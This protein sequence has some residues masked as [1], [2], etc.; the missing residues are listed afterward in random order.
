MKIQELQNWCYKL[1]KHTGERDSLFLLAKLT[2]EL[3]E[4][5][6]S[7]LELRGERQLHPEQD[8]LGKELFDMLYNMLTIAAIHNVDLIQEF[9]TAIEKYE[10]RFNATNFW[11]ERN[12]DATVG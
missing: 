12:A 5:T 7:F 8:T 1:E 3:G 6:K 9:K 2:E 10:K 11:E 4:F